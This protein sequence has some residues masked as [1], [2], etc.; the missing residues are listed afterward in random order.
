LTTLPPTEL[1]P[2]AGY[3]PLV[4]VAATVQLPEAVEE[5]EDALLLEELEALDD[6]DDEDED[7]VVDVLDVLPPPQA[8]STPP[9]PAPASRAR[10]RRL[11]MIR[12]KSSARL[13][14][15]G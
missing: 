2:S 4:S 3:G 5:D 6:E 11:A 7:A 8:A 12:F 1:V 15:S 13:G 10:V 9:A 14:A